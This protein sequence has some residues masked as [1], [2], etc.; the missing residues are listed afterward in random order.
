MSS[1]VLFHFKTYYFQQG[2]RKFSDSI[3]WPIRAVIV[4]GSSWERERGEGGGGKM[5]IIT[6]DPGIDTHSKKTHTVS[7]LTGSKRKKLF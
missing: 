4:L 7:T 3:L 2:R 5:L 6:D 1:T